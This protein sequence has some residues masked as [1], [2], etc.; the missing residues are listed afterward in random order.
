MGTTTLDTLAARLEATVFGVWSMDETPVGSVIDETPLNS[1]APISNPNRAAK[2]S[3][4]GIS[5]TLSSPLKSPLHKGKV[6]VGGVV[7]VRE[8]KKEEK[9]EKSSRQPRALAS[10]TENS[11]SGNPF[12]VEKQE[13]IAATPPPPCAPNAFGMASFLRIGRKK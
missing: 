5:F 11:K 12:E 13:E 4:T 6:A 9:R 10:D 2:A 1:P 8:K 3:P 7:E